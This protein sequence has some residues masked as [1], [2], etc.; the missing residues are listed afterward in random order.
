MNLKIM[1]YCNSVI[2]GLMPNVGASL[3]VTFSSRI[4]D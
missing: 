3:L 4:L 1:L 2:A